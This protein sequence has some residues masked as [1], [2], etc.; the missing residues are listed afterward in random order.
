MKRA[1]KVAATRRRRGWAAVATTVVALIGV[2]FWL[3]PTP[4]PTMTGAGTPRVAVDRTEIDLGRLPFEQP[5]R[6]TFTL[7]NAGDGTLTLDGS[8]PVR[9]VEGC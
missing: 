2:A 8:P 9:A 7:T 5:A 3:W 4:G 6:A 1:G